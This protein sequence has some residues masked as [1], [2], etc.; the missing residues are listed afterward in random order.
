M[1]AFQDDGRECCE[2]CGGSI[3]G[4]GVGTAFGGTRC[5]TCNGRMYPE[6]LSD[7]VPDDCDSEENAEP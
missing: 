2:S 3:A 7:F 6:S 4:G 1:P 5:W